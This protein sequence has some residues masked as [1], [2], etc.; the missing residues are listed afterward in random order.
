MVPRV[1]QVPMHAVAVVS[2]VLAVPGV[3]VV[4]EVLTDHRHRGVSGRTVTLLYG[5]SPPYIC[6]LINKQYFP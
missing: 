5:G 4:P 1:L 3:P 2:E 6:L